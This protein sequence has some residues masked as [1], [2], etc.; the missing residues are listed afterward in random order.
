MSVLMSK[1]VSSDF[2][3]C[4][5]SCA[6][7]W[8]CGVCVRPCVYVFVTEGVGLRVD[9]MWSVCV[10]I[11]VCF[12]FQLL[13]RDRP[14]HLRTIFTTPSK[15]HFVCAVSVVNH[16]LWDPSLRSSR[17]ATTASEGHVA[18]WYHIVNPPPLLPA[19]RGGDGDV[20]HTCSESRQTALL[21][22]VTTWTVSLSRRGQ[23]PQ[24]S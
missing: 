2:C 11:G 5:E 23:K 13:V 16:L 1:C 14:S 6:H 7:C 20:T 12:F 4:A 18:S 8:A 17:E 10:F 22:V 21:C 24:E 9:W 19:E 15:I 3:V